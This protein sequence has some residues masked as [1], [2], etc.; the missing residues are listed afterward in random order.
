[1]TQQVKDLVLSRC[2]SGYSC[3]EGLIPGLGASACCRHGQKEKE[4]RKIEITTTAD[5][6]GEELGL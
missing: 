1:M 4:K 2:G 6:D 3:V 5:K